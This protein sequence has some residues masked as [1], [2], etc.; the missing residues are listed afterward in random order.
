MPSEI[1]LNG[2]YDRQ[3]RDIQYLGVAKQLPTGGYQVLAN[4]YGALC[5]VEVRLTPDY[6]GYAVTTCP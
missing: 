3:G 5:I 4:Y 6:T 1:D 2:R